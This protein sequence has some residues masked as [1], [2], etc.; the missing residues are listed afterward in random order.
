V[1]TLDPENEGAD[2]ISLL[3]QQDFPE[4]GVTVAQ[5]GTLGAPNAPR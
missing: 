2:V 5:D 4:T 1:P 3:S